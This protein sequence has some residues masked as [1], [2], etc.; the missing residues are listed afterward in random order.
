MSFG[1]SFGFMQNLFKKKLNGPNPFIIK[2]KASSIFFEKHGPSS[3]FIEYNC[4]TSDCDTNVPLIGNS[5]DVFH[6][7]GKTGLGFGEIGIHI[8]WYKRVIESQ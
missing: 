2:N 7:M 4:Y 3:A 8:L 6:L 1:T 5:I